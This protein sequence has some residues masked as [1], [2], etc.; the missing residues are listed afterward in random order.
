[1]TSGRSTYPAKIAGLPRAGGRATRP[2]PSA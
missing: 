1:M 2:A